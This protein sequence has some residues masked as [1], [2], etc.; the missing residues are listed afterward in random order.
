M[1]AVFWIA[2]RLRITGTSG[3][4]HSAG[5]VIAVAGVALAVMVMEITLAVVSGFKSEITRKITGFDS[6]ITIERPYDYASGLQKEYISLS[7]E[8][9]SSVPDINAE[10]VK[11]SLSMQ[12]PGMIKTDS[13]FAG[14]I[15]IGRDSKHD[16]TFERG[17]IIDGV[18]PDYSDEAKQNDIVISGIT[19]N[20]LGLSPGDK[21]FVYFFID[22]SLKTRKVSIAGIYESYLSEYDK[23][24]VYASMD[25]LQKVAGID[26]S[27]GTHLELS[28]YDP[29][30]IEAKGKEIEY[31]LNY[32][33]ADGQLNKYYPV[34]TIM[35]TGAMYFNWLSLL[36]TNVIVIFV[37]MLCVALFTLVSSLYLIVLD[38]IPTIGIM[39]SI[40]AS[41]NWLSQLFVNIGMKLAVTGIII[42]NAA[43]LGI[44]ILQQH[45]GFI[46]LDPEMYYL[47]QVPVKMEVLP[48]IFLNL[49]MLLLSWLIL[50]IPSRSAARIDATE[51]MRYEW[52]AK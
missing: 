5:A 42:G 50:Y 43:G 14:T 27:S 17:N 7:P 30:M 10:G 38:R 24:I 26:Q 8:I 46:G 20:A 1:N 4:K 13:D 16:V 12:L 18:F 45:T 37:L 44:C 52:T 36:D 6:Q 49:G 34:T 31:E 39:K 22:N 40:G 33:S 15:F 35:Q 23:A 9:M 32:S 41:K 48:M 47:S 19:A 2:R 28:G 29:E 21:V 51:S 3:D 25:F 11:A